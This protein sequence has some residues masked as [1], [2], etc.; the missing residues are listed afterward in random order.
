MTGRRQGLG[1]RGQR[2]GA[3]ALPVATRRRQ[4]GIPGSHGN[5]DHG[6]CVRRW[7]KRFHFAPTSCS[8]LNA[9]EGYFANLSQQRLKHGVFRS[10]VELQQ[11]IKRFIEETNQMPKPF[12]WTADPDTIV[13]AVKRGHHVLNSIH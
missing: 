13:A 8:W 2:L 9:V 11:A 5:I 1:G 4:R 3:R 7:Q 6:G 12:V 10:V